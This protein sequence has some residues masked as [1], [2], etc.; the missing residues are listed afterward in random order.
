VL[1]QQ[2]T[3]LRLPEPAHGMGAD[4]RKS[5]VPSNSITNTYTKAISALVLMPSWIRLR[6]SS[7]G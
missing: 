3:S 5:A 4:K 7:H 1:L 2:S 6:S